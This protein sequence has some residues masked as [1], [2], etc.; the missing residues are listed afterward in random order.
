M[1][2]FRWWFGKLITY[3]SDTTDFNQSTTQF[4]NM[5][6]D[7]STLFWVHHDRL[8]SM[9]ISTPGAPSQIDTISIPGSSGCGLRVTADGSTA[10]VASGSA[11]SS[12][13]G[14]TDYVVAYD[15]SDPANLTKI[16]DLSNPDLH[17]GHGIALGP[18]ENYLYVTAYRTD[19]FTAVDVSDTTNMS[20]TDAVAATHVHDVAI[21][22]GGN[23]AFASAHDSYFYSFD[24]SDPTNISK[25]ATIDYTGLHTNGAA[26]RLGPNEEYFYMGCGGY[27]LT[28]DITDPA[29]PAEVDRLADKWNP[30][31][32]KIDGNRMYGSV[33]GDSGD[34]GFVPVYDIS[35]PSSPAKLDDAQSDGLRHIEVEYH[36][37]ANYVYA[38]DTDTQYLT[39]YELNP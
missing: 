19:Q 12:S 4:R 22:S 35:T 11:A 21:E 20:V 3:S 30:Y 9:D 13:G 10:F 8:L 23:Y 1:G 17:G 27:L 15:V 29:N 16:S 2:N 39:V 26:A 6:T 36:P 31:R 34:Q 24:I 37:S 38:A 5:D 25:L 32:L 33:S 14:S 18:N 7:G 28:I